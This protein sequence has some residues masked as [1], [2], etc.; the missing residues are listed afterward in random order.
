[1][2][3]ITLPDGSK[4]E[5][6]NAVTVFD[7]AADIGAGLAKVALAG[8]VNGELVDTSYTIAEDADLAIVTPRDEEGLEV[9]RHSCA[10]LMAMAVQELFP[11]AQVNHRS[12]D[13]RRFLLRLCLRSVRSRRKIC[14]R[15][16]TR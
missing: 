12:C 14:R 3:V 6:A 13:R 15:S 7:V 16:R 10:H 11:T 4:R 2:P 9:I 5:F 8:K 1:M